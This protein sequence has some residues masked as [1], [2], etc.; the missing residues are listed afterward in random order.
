MSRQKTTL[1]VALEKKSVDHQSQQDIL[2]YISL[3]QSV[4][5]TDELTSP[6]TELCRL[7]S[8]WSLYLQPLNDRSSDASSEACMA[9]LETIS[10][11]SVTCGRPIVTTVCWVTDFLN[12]SLKAI[13]TRR[14]LSQSPLNESVASAFWL[15]LQCLGLFND[16]LMAWLYYLSAAQTTLNTLRLIN[17]ASTKTPN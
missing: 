3:D 15:Q 11:H 10:V 12:I 7:A 16:M 8:T 9:F 4:R 1:L 17:P 5:P 2:R 14:L 13:T 6:F